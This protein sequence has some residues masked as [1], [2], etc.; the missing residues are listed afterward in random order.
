MNEYISKNYLN[1]ILNRYLENSSG[2]EHYAYERIKEEI[3][4]AVVAKVL[5]SKWINV[6]DFGD[7]NCYGYCE[8]CGNEQKAKSANALRAFCKY[9]SWCGANM[10]ELLICHGNTPPSTEEAAKKLYSW[11]LGE[12]KDNG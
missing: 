1:L 3:N 12:F 7:G 9:C 2:A 8:N 5:R 6:V 10:D 4:G 11:S